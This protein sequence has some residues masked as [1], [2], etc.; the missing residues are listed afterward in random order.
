MVRRNN[1]NLQTGVAGRLYPEK[2]EPR[3]KTVERMA[4]T[5]GGLFAP[6]VR[7]GAGRFRDIANVVHTHGSPMKDWG[8]QK[9]LEKARELGPRLRREG[10]TKDLVAQTFAA[11]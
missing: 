10:Y 9:I 5:L 2:E 4:S 6:W 11:L 3:L 8:E 1:S 7:P